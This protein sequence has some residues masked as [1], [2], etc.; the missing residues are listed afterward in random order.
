MND[1]NKEFGDSPVLQQVNAIAQELKEFRISVEDRF[2]KI[3]RETLRISTASSQEDNKSLNILDQ[4]YSLSKRRNT[5]SEMYSVSDE[6]AEGVEQLQRV[7]RSN[8]SSKSRKKV[9]KS[10]VA[11]LALRIGLSELANEQIRGQHVKGLLEVVNKQSRRGLAK[12][13]IE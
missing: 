3:E 13:G 11:E 5:V 12:R 9:T 4:E 6:I 10:F 7:I 1:S 2:Q 8:L